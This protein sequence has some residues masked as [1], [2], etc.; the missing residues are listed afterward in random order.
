M[1]WVPERRREVSGVGDDDGVGGAEHLDLHAD[2][3]PPALAVPDGDVEGVD[4]LD[5][6]AARPL[7]VGHVEQPWWLFSGVL[8]F[9]D[10]TVNRLNDFK[11]L[12]SAQKGHFPHFSTYMVPKNS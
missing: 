2:E 11:L 5:A 3:G 9:H 8:K 6:E 1:N 7:A 12:Q 4:A 10:K